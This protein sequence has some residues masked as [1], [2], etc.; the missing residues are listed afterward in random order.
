LGTKGIILENS[1]NTYYLATIF[2]SSTPALIHFTVISLKDF[3]VQLRKSSP[4]CWTVSL[5]SIIVMLG[6]AVS[7]RNGQNHIK[8]LEYRK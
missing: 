1:R 6:F 5:F 7:K 8:N 3:A 2:L 4:Y